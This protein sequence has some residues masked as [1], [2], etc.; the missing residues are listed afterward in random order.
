MFVG[1]FVYSMDLLETSRMMH[2]N[3]E[4]YLVIIENS[5]KLKKFIDLN[6]DGIE[7]QS[8]FSNLPKFRLS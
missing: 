1:L 5:R 6:L 3:D 4:E 7:F 8:S 2:I